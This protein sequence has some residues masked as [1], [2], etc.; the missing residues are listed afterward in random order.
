MLDEICFNGGNLNKLFEVRVD[1]TLKD[2]KDQLDDDINQRL[3]PRDTRR[4]KYVWYELPSF[5]DGRI[6]FS[7]SKLKN[8]E[9]VRKMF[10]IF[11]QCSMFP[12]I[13]MDALLLRSP[14]DILKS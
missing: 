11:G 14:E 1:V 8:D 13:E 2:L 12:T 10:S 3:N 6:T 7:R 5:D 4:V 9:D